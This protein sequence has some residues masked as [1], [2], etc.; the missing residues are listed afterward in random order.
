MMKQTIPILILSI[1][2][3]L[4]LATVAVAYYLDKRHRLGTTG[5]AGSLV[6]LLA[7]LPAPAARVEVLSK[8]G[9]VSLSFQIFMGLKA[10]SA[11]MEELAVNQAA[12][13]QACDDGWFTGIHHRSRASTVKVALD[14]KSALHTDKHLQIKRKLSASAI[15]FSFDLPKALWVFDEETVLMVMKFAILTQMVSVRLEEV[16]LKPYVQV[17]DL[18]KRID[19]LVSFV[20]IR[21]LLDSTS[22]YPSFV[23]LFTMFCLNGEYRAEE[24]LVFKKVLSCVFLNAELCLP[25]DYLY[26]DIE[27]SDFIS[28]ADTFEVPDKNRNKIA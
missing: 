13:S 21:N 22:R 19:R 27:V 10:T 23:S 28:K 11:A 17:P 1:G 25:F 20:L 4:I 5:G 15:L 12:W 24:K 6:P 9:W 3:I 14:M 16:E 18:L 2:S 8:M 26:I 7:S